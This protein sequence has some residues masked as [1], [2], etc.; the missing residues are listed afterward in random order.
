[1]KR[2]LAALLATAVAVLPGAGSAQIVEDLPPELEG[3]GITE[4]LG[5]TLPLGLTFKNEKGE[6]TALGSYFEAGKP[7]LLN[8]VYFDCPMLC[9]VFLDGVVAGLSEL[10]WTPGDQFEIVTVSIDPRD[11]PEGARA[12]QAHYVE[13]LG[14]PEAAKGWHFLTGTIEATEEL[15]DVIGF[16]YRFDERSGEFMH[17]ACLFVSTPDA[18]LAR[19]LYGVWFEPQTLRLSLVEASDGAIGSTM[20]QVL[21]FCF[22]YDHTQGRYGPAAFKIMRAG[23]ALTVVILGAFLVGLGWR[24]KDRKKTM[25][26]GAQH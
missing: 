2:A 11:D 6:T 20:D 14:R 7:V 12:K 9:N 23:G 21:L 24:R 26:L 10:D 1:M 16:R 18:R 15:A 4:H 3:V 13:K 19:Y 25:N 17:S 8:L 22:A 5:A